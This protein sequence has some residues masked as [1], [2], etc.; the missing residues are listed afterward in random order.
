LQ[1]RGHYVQS[2]EEAERLVAEVFA[3]PPNMWAVAGSSH[4]LNN[5]VR[6]T[7]RQRASPLQRLKHAFNQVLPRRGVVGGV[8]LEKAYNDGMATVITN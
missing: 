3:W 2:F 5:P 6:R 8:L 7:H 1:Y 4:P